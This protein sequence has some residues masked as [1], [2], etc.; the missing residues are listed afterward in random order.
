MSCILSS[1]QVNAQV[2]YIG[3]GFHQ[4]I[5]FIVKPVDHNPI[6][7]PAPKSPEDAP[8]VY[9]ENNVLYFDGD[10]PSYYLTLRDED[11]DTVYTTTVS[12]SDT[13][14]TLPSTLSGT[15]EIEL[16]Y[17]DLLFTGWIDL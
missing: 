13:V 6:G 1:T 8:V 12:A 3:G 16:V 2:N 15:Y 14:V 7:H 10:H 9:Q 11:G 5:T 17:N 4:Y